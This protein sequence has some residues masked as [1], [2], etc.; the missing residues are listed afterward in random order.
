MSEERN[1]ILEKIADSIDKLDLESVESAIQEATEVG[2]SPREIVEKGLMKGLEIVGDKYDRHEYFLSELLMSAEIASSIMKSL[3]PQ[4]ST[5]ERQVRGKVVIGTVQGDLHDIGKN[6]VASLLKASGFEVYDLG[7]D[8]PPEKFVEKIKDVKPNIVGMSAL[9]TVVIP[10]LKRTIEKIERAGLRENVKIM[11]G[12]RAISSE[13]VGEV[14][15]DAYCEDAWQ[16][17]R[18]ALELT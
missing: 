7:I 13:I 10:S 1:K 15:A 18:K 6:L 11:L 2:L 8:V 5:E 17:V 3:G 14:G 4:L 9:L 16:G 12:G